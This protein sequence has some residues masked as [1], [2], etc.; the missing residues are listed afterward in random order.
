MG[1]G[2]KFL[3][4]IWVSNFSWYVETTLEKTEVNNNK[5]K[6]LKQGEVALWGH[7]TNKRLQ[8]FLS[9][10]PVRKVLEYRQICRENAN[11]NTYF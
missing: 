6:P 10:N 8:N 4:C 7:N 9:T 2:K 3:S 11:N 1:Y 5:A